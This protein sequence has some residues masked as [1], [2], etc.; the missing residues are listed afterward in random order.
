V[1]NKLKT[2]SIAT[3]P[4]SYVT[5]SQDHINYVTDESRLTAPMVKRIFFPSDIHQVAGALQSVRRLGESCVVSGGRTGVTGASVP[6]GSQAVVSLEKMKD[7]LDFRHDKNSYFIRC[8]PGMSLKELQQMLA[9]RTL[10]PVNDLAVA[11]NEGRIERLWFPVNP[12][13]SSAHLGGVVANN[14]SGARTYGYG[15]TREWVQALK[16]VLADGDV[17]ELRRGEVFCRSN[18]FSLCKSDGME[19]DLNFVDFDYPQTKCTCG[20]YMRKDMDLL[21]LFIGSEGTLGAIVEIELRLDIKPEKSCGVMLFLSDEQE[22]VD[23]VSEVNVLGHCVAMEYFDRQSLR[24]VNESKPGEYNLESWDC[25]A[26]YLEFM[27]RE[28]DIRR[29]LAQL[30]ELVGPYEIVS[31]WAAYNKRE[32]RMQQEFR[33]AVPEAVN[34]LIAERK[35][36]NPKIHKIG[37]DMAVPLSNLPYIMRYYRRTLQAQQLDAVIFGHIGDGHVHVNILPDTTEDIDKAKQLYLQWAA[38]IVRSGGAVSAEHGVG[39]I[40]KAMLAVQYPKEVLDCMRVIRCAFDPGET[41]S[42]GVLVDMLK[43]C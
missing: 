4:C 9:N 42:P 41:L 16:I 1:Q 26:L 27:G 15:S 17:L 36:S 12:T 40:K 24:L 18:S 35:K 13:E 21:D 10:S 8:Q 43:S 7:L 20:Y 31:D 25:C 33:H 2:Y 23:L 37:T 34:C 5:G 39:R 22:V 14:A 38:E 11:Y 29:Y 30:A 6:I 3:K 28:S 19:Y 32:L